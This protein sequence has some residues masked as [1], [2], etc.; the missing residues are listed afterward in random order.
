MTRSCL[1]PLLLALALMGGATWN[2]AAATLPVQQ[3]PRP[4]LS[5]LVLRLDDGRSYGLSAQELADA[6]GGAV[7]WNDWAVVNLLM[8]FALHS[9]RSPWAS[10]S[11]LRLWFTPGP[12]G[13]LPPFL[14]Q[15]ADGPRCPLDSDG[16]TKGSAFRRTQVVQIL[17]GYEDGRVRLL[18]GEDL[19]D[20]RSGVMVWNDTAVANLLLP[21]YLKARSLPTRADD[22]LRTWTT[23]IATTQKSSLVATAELPGFL[24]KPRCIPYYPAAE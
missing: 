12:S 5:S 8:P 16:P 14:L 19:N 15:T 3:A 21:F 11:V 20:R 17:V 24:V 1:R 2:A 22:V 9:R 4:K 10:D 18:Q 7:F 6:E 23:P 13:E